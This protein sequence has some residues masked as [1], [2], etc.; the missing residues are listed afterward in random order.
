MVK[1]PDFD[2]LKLAKMA[3]TKNL[4]KIV[5]NGLLKGL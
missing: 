1:N 5:L 4:V 3:R 2:N